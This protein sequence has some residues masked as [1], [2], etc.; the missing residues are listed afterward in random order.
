MR[1]GGLPARALRIAAA[2]WA[3]GAASLAGPATAGVFDDDFAREQIT[4]TQKDL[5]DFRDQTAARLQKLEERS[6]ERFDA[7]Q[8]TQVDLAN[9]IEAIRTEL[10]KLRGQIEVVQHE[11]DAGAKRQRDFYVDLDGR[12]RKVETAAG[13]LATKIAEIPPPPPPKPKVDPDAEPRSY[14]AAINLFKDK[15]YK[16]AQTGFQSFMRDY[17]NSNLVSSAQFWFA[18]TL[19]LQR[20]CKGAIDAHTV[21]IDRHPG[22]SLAPDALLAISTCQQELNDAKAARKTLETLVARYPQ[23]SAAETAR[24]RLKRK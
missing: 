19:Y 15:K 21:V 8:R 9:Q 17:P 18:N 20:D 24:Q 1:G 14:E 7:I 10:A 11:S 23:S 6:A 4:K 12:L 22:S 5:A 2:L 3:I 16:E 13:D